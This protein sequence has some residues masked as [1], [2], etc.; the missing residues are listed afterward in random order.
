MGPGRHQRVMHIKR[1]ETHMRSLAGR[2]GG[3][4]DGKKALR[5]KFIRFTHPTERNEEIRSFLRIEV[6]LR[7]RKGAGHS[8]SRKDD[9]AGFPALEELNE[10]LQNSFVMLGNVDET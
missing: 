8:F 6:N 4:I 3:S 7:K 9:A 1:T 2:I 5:P 10:L